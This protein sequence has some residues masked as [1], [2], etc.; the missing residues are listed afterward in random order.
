MSTHDTTTAELAP[1]LYLFTCAEGCG[2]SFSA[3]L[4]DDGRLDFANRQ[5]IDEG[6]LTADHRGGIGGLVISGVEVT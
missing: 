1:D 6:D 5:I 2:Y 4:D 3:G